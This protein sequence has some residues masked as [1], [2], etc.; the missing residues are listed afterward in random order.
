MTPVGRWPAFST[1]L[2][3]H[4]C[5]LLCSVHSRDESTLNR[6][7]VSFVAGALLEERLMPLGQ[8]PVNACGA[9][10]GATLQAGHQR[11]Q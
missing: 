11:R 3:S 8:D 1:G 10:A 9:L 4:S 7:C 5:R 2:E 6:A